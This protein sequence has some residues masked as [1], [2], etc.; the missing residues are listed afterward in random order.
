MKI[1]GIETGCDETASAVV[2]GGHSVLSNIISSQISKHVLFGGVVPELAAREHLE[3]ISSVV[4]C[5]ISDA[6]TE[7]DDIEAVAVTRTPGLLPALLVGISYAKG[8]AVGLDVPIVGI[9]HFLAHIFGA[10][11]DQQAAVED[12]ATYPI[13]AL[14]VSGGH[15]ALT[16]IDQ[17]GN[18]KLVGKT[19]DDAA[20][21]AFDKGA[22]ILKLNYPVGPVIDKLSQ[23]GRPETHDFPR[24]LCGG[25]GSS[26]RYKDR[27]N[28]SFS[29]VKTSLK[30]YV[31]KRPRLFEKSVRNDR[32]RQSDD[33]EFSQ[34]FLD[35]TA[36]YQE[37]VVDALVKKTFMAAEYFCAKTLILCGGVACNSRL[38][39]KMQDDA[40]EHNIP[41]I[42]AR[43]EYC[44]D[45]A[46]MIAGI[47]YYYVRNGHSGS[48]DFDAS[49]RLEAL[50]RVPFHAHRAS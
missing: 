50:D 22:K 14:I 46:A 31:Q 16:L 25:R 48:L 35:I 6:G 33:L 24:G 12:K 41:L 28:F 11:L 34:D 4:G 1:L 32:T 2:E 18:C 29:G 19:L 7:L 13:L 9:N 27:F 49:P 37:A 47:G 43:P 45:N 17:Y 44:T 23:K 40:R 39:I 5:A 10:L 38:R 26:V 36:S 8:L 15:T 21:E 42:T 3:R 30:Y 20:G